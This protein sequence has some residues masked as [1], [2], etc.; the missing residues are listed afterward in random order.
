M[1][2]KKK[3]EATAIEHHKSLHQTLG[4]VSSF[5]PTQDVIFNL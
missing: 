1:K 2:K 5:L 4:G 3:A